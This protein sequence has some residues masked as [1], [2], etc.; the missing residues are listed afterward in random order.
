M[1][2]C[3]DQQCL[4]ELGFTYTIVNDGSHSLNV[5]DILRDFNG[6]QS[7]SLLN[8]LTTSSLTLGET[9]TLEET[10]GLD[11]CQTVT[12]VTTVDVDGQPDD[13]PECETASDYTVDIA[14]QCAVDV[15][16]TCEEADTNTACEDLL[17]LGTP[18]CVC[19]ECSFVSGSF[20]FFFMRQVSI[21][22]FKHCTEVT[23]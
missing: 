16:L 15:D 2:G 18:P 5:V 11:I 10:V 8:D 22:T 3:D 6:E 23:K 1:E 19:D 20:R 13:G 14:P 9:T 7:T 12:L 21:Q 17:S 4:Q